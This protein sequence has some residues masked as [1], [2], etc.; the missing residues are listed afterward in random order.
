MTCDVLS[1]YYKRDDSDIYTLQVL[2]YSSPEEPLLVTA[3]SNAII[4]QNGI[5]SGLFRSNVSISTNL[6]RPKNEDGS[7]NFL[8]SG[9]MTITFNDEYNSFISWNITYNSPTGKLPPGGKYIINLSS[10]GG[11]YLNKPGIIVIDVT[12]KF[13]K[14][15]VKFNN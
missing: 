7:D 13:C 4:Y 12:T 9:L 1:V 14:F 5:V 8:S 3:N 11:I 15:Y 10:G 6:S 2:P